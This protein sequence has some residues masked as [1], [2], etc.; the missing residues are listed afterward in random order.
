MRNFVTT[1]MNKGQG[2]QCIE[3][4]TRG[5]VRN[6]RFDGPLTPVFGPARLARRLDQPGLRHGARLVE[7]ALIGV[8]FIEAIIGWQF[9]RRGLQSLTEQGIGRVEIAAIGGDALLQKGVD[10]IRQIAEIDRVRAQ[11]REME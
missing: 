9:L 5:A 11:G 4:E 3:R 10:G 7:I 2:L 8:D 1:Q 6:T